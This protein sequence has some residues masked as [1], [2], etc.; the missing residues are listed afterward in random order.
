MRQTLWR[1]AY[2]FHAP[3]RVNM[4]R[5]V[6]SQVSANPSSLLKE[7]F[8]PFWGPAAVKEYPNSESFSFFFFF[9]LFRRS[10]SLCSP[11][12]MSTLMFSAT[13]TRLST[14]M[15]ISMVSLPYL[16]SPL[17]TKVFNRFFFV[18]FLRIEKTTRS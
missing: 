11:A 2:G 16:D 4:E 6:V 7:S 14:L 10:V 17:L 3:L 9:F 12:R 8:L 5:T 15:T 18:F 1:N 13:A